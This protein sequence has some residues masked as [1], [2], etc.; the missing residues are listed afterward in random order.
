MIRNLRAVHTH[1]HAIIFLSLYYSIITAI[2]TII[3]TLITNNNYNT[4]GG[5]AQGVW[6]EQP[7]DQEPQSCIHTHTHNNI[8]SQF[9]LLL[10]KDYYNN[11][12]N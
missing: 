1:T 11:L 7:G 10:N 5:P 2:Q 8:L 6:V 12:Y 4:D 9:T 3:I